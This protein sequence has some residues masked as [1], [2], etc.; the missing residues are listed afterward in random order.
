MCVPFIPECPLWWRTFVIHQRINT[1]SPGKYEGWVRDSLFQSHY[2]C[3]M[4]LMCSPPPLTRDWVTPNECSTRSL[5]WSP[6][7]GCRRTRG[8]FVHGEKS[9]DLWR[10]SGDCSPC[11]NYLWFPPSG[12]SFYSG[13]WSLSCFCPPHYLDPSPCRYSLVHKALPWGS[14]HRNSLF[15]CQCDFEKH[16]LVFFK[17]KTKCPVKE[18]VAHTQ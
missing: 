17:P 5:I 12:K 4:L 10:S 1:I 2:K 13:L 18:G 3:S 7:G 16:H 15:P 11:P 8:A 9:L 14:F 6:H